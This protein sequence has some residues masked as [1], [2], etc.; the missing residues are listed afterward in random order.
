MGP[1]AS[2][3][4]VGRDWVKILVMGNKA[5]AGHTHEDKGSFVLEFAGDTFAMD[6]GTCDYSSPLAGI[7]SNCERHNMLVPYGFSERPAPQKPLMTAIIP[8]ARGDRIR[9]NAEADFT[10][11]WKTYYRRWVRSWSSPTSDRLTII[12]DYELE[13]GYGV[14]FY[15]QTLLDVVLSE[16]RVV[17]RGRRGRVEITPPEGVEVRLDE[18]PLLDGIQKRIVFRHAGRKGRL[19]TIVRL[20]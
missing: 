8:R 9:F 20:C 1:V 5:G 7:V 13:R 19:E 16:G 3:R 6:P 12:D 14:E 11:G 10:P 15:W 2:T 4:R 17:I 18:L